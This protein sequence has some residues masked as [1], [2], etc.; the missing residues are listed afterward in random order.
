MGDE[1]RIENKRA[2]PRFS[3]ALD[4]SCEVIETGKTQ[5][6]QT[7]DLSMGG[8]RVYSREK[9]NVGDKVAVTIR[10]GKLK[11][12]KVNAEVRWVRTTQ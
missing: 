9:L 12:M 7:G 6:G 11:K 4:V 8:V 2:H 10:L 3:M 1:S 5:E